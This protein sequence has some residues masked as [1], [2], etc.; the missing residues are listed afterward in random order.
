M[1][2]PTHEDTDLKDVGDFDDDLN[3]EQWAKHGDNEKYDLTEL[4]F[5]K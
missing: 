1:T 5:V 2:I 3:A 4:D